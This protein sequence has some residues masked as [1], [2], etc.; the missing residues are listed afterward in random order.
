MSVCVFMCVLMCVYVVMYRM[1]RMYRGR[2]WDLVSDSELVTSTQISH[3]LMD[4]GAG[5]YNL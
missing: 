2:F 4:A 3:S 5:T 1:Y